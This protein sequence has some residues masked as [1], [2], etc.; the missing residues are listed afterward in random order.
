MIKN[1]FFDIGNVL[2]DIHPEDCFQYWT[3][4][5][6]LKKDEKIKALSTDLHNN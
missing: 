3:D 5:T 4:S 1:I 6:N 2:I